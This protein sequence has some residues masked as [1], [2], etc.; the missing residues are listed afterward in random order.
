MKISEKY[1]SSS[2]INSLI[3]NQ[4]AR[5]HLHYFRRIKRDAHC[6]TRKLFLPC[7]VKDENCSFVAIAPHHPI[8]PIFV[9]QTAAF[10]G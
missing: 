1:F 7:G 3:R 8:S 9:V 2:Q 5:P 10:E 6:F 4:T